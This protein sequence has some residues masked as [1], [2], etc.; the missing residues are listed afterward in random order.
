V[1]EQA[2]HRISVGDPVRLKIRALQEEN[3]DLISGRVTFVAVAPRDASP[4]SGTGAGTG[5]YL[6]LVALNGSDRGALELDRLRAGYTVEGRIITR[7][8]NA[9]RLLWVRLRGM[10]RREL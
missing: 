10:T 4:E 8:G 2:I 9:L 6:V 7:S 1:P 5:G 3:P